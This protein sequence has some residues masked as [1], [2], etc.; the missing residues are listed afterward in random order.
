MDRK[1]KFCRLIE[2][3]INTKKKDLIFEAYGENSFIQI[4]NLNYSISNP[5][6]L[7]EATI[8]L[9]DEIDESILDRSIADYIIIESI[10]YFFPDIPTKVLINWDV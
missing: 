7:V 4:K 5:T 3:I 1:R 9:K 6:I 8:V 10:P 2:K